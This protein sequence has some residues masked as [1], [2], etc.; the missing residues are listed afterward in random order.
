MEEKGILRLHVLS[1]WMVT[2]LVLLFVSGMIINLFVTFPEIPEITLQSNQYQPLFIEYPV[3]L[4][5]FLL[6]IIL[7][8]S[9]LVALVMSYKAKQT[10]IIRISLIGFLSVLIAVTYGLVFVQYVFTNNAYSFDMS[11]SALFALVAY[12]AMF[13]ETKSAY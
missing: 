1:F 4:A 12:L 13:Y 6:G 3:L 2:V 7:L 5:H 9:A 11:L 8:I 10:K